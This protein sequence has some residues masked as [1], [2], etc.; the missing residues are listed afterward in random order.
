MAK[1]KSTRRPPTSSSLDSFLTELGHAGNRPD[2]VARIERLRR[3]LKAG[4][5]TDDEWELIEIGRA[6]KKNFAQ[7]LST[8]IAQ[9]TADA[10]R[11]TFKGI[12]PD[13]HGHKHESRAAGARGMKK[14]DVN[15]STTAAGLGLAISIKTINFFDEATGRYTKNVKRV[16]GELRAEAQDCHERQPYAVLAVYLFMPEDASRDGTGASSLKHAAE[17]LA[18][19]AGRERHTDDHSLFEQAFLGVYFPDGTVKFFRAMKPGDF[20]ETGLPEQSRT[21]TETLAEVGKVYAARNVR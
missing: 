15:Y 16:D 20:S 1:P 10:L 19:R 18:L 3:K 4:S 7:R 9:K 8:S 2:L 13:E 12:L 6:A 5:L 11:P 17:T 14:L 21:F